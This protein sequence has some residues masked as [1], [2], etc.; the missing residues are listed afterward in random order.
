MKFD[1]FLMK[2]QYCRGRDRIQKCFSNGLCYDFQ[3]L[4]VLWAKNT[5]A[6]KF[7]F[8]PACANFSLSRKPL[9]WMTRSKSF[10]TE[11]F[12]WVSSSR[13]KIWRNKKA[14]G[15][16]FFCVSGQKKLFRSFFMCLGE[17]MA[18]SKLALQHCNTATHKHYWTWMLKIDSMLDLASTFIKRDLVHHH[19]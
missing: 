10:V 8:E 1:I 18:H 15:Q 14:V 19:Q 6:I 16:N 5:T 11:I 12:S 7:S 9:F 17:K 4:I 3:W 2:T 13:K